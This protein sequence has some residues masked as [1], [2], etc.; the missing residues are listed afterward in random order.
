[1]TFLAKEGSFS[2]S[3]Y[4]AP[5][6]A[7]RYQITVKHPKAVGTATVIVEGTEAISIPTKIV[8]EKQI[9]AT[10]EEIIVLQA[11]ILDQNNLPIS[12]NIEWKAN[13]G[14]IVEKNKFKAGKIP[15]VYKIIA[16]QP[17]SRL[18]EEISVIISKPQEISPEYEIIVEPKEIIIA[19]N[20]KQPLQ[21]TILQ[22]KKIIL[23]WAWEITVIPSEGKYEDGIY[24]A[25]SNPGHYRLEVRYLKSSVRIPIQVVDLQLQPKEIKLSPGQKQKFELQGSW[26]E[27]SQ[28]LNWK[29]TGGN[30]EQDGTYVAG[31][32]PGEYSIHVYF[33]NNLMATSTVKVLTELQKLVI[34]PETIWLQPFEMC[35]FIVTGMAYNGENIPVEI[36]WEAKGGKIENDGRFTAGEEEGQFYVKAIHSDG[37]FAIATVTIQHGS[38]ESISINPPSITLLPGTQQ[39][40]NLQGLTK[41]KRVASVKP[42]WMATGGV[43]TENGLYT[44]GDT[45]GNYEVTGIDTES[46]LRTRAYIKI[47]EPPEEN[48]QSAQSKSFN[49]YVL[50]VVP[51][52]QTVSPGFNLPLR[53][54]LTY[55]G[56]PVQCYPWDFRYTCSGGIMIGQYGN[57]WIAPKRPGKYS[58]FVSHPV[59]NLT[60]TMTVQEQNIS[61]NSTNLNKIARLEITPKQIT[62]TPSQTCKFKI[63]AYNNENR[64]V[65]C[66]INWQVFGG[67]IDQNGNFVAGELQGIYNIR[68]ELNTDRNIFA[69]AEVTI[70]VEESISQKNGFVYGVGLRQ[71]QKSVRVVREY[72]YST[73]FFQQLEAI[74]QFKKGF[75]AGYGIQGNIVFDGIWQEN[76][77]DLGRAYGYS[78]SNK[79]LSQYDVVNVLR[80]Y[81]LRLSERDQ[82]LFRRGFIQGHPF[83]AVIYKQLLNQAQK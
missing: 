81:V 58:I 51:G 65:D 4:T 52:N 8:V 32:N 74:E 71:G 24:I 56:T 76:L 36:T 55:Q 47:I 39:Q 42:L 48:S 12:A 20:S 38:A 16:T 61:N 6:Q 18:R 45:P 75:I 13:G 11:T 64:E 80:Q 31:R 57:I 63:Q 22:N 27:N 73:L 41:T 28:K 37:T 2:D 14:I 23:P 78:L 35:Q 69:T 72:F 15:G 9:K 17:D 33:N 68:A 34:T 25:P 53:S 30:I 1:M 70:K 46:H 59:A 62:L 83:G 67:K 79:N 82:H 5:Y 3:I 19:P 40:F 43:I 44:A 21:I 29:A 10:C 66:V 60:L 54:S 26:A 50:K 77:I 49:G 7:G